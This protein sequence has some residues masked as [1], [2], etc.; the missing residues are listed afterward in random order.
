MLRNHIK[1]ALR[2]FWK[3]KLTTGINIF[4]L[5]IG[6][7]CASLA[8]IFIQHERSY[9]TFHEEYENIYWLHTSHQGGQ[10]NL[11]TTPAV[12]STSLKKNF[13][14]VTEAFRM[15]DHAISIKVGKEIFE[16]E[17]LLV[18]SNF[19]D[20]FSFPLLEGN[21]ND[22]LQKRNA[23]VLSE[24]MANKYF[25]R[26]SPI[27]KMLNI[28][29]RGQE[30]TFEVTGVA[31]DAPANSS[32]QFSVLIPIQYRYKEDL[33]KLNSDWSNFSAA[34]FIR[35]R[36]A[37]DIKSLEEKMPGFS[38]LHYEEEGAYEFVLHA[39]QDYHL[40]D[41]M[42][43]R[44]LVAKGETSY[45]NILSIIAILI[46]LV[47]CLNF[48]NLSNARGSQ[49]LTEI[50][51]RQVLGAERNQLLRQFLTESVLISSLSLGIAIGFI[52]LFQLYGSDLFS[53]NL[54][55]DWYSPKILLPLVGIT[56]ITGL[57]AGIYPSILLSNLKPIN[58]FKSD[59]KVGGN[60]WVTKGGLVFQ[61]TLSI[62]LLA[63]T[64]I[65]FQ[66]QQYLKNK[67]L[68][69]DQEQVVV[70]P[71]QIQRADSINTTR[72]LEQYKSKV[73]AHSGVQGVTAVSNSFARGNRAQF[74][75]EEDGTMGFVFEYSVADNYLDLLDIELLEGRN[76]SE[77]IQ[78]DQGK[79]VIVNEAFA[80]KYNIESIEGYRLPEKFGDFA[81]SSVVGLV[82]DYHFST[83]K[84]SV[85]PMMMHMNPDLRYG[86]LL[87]KI[88]PNEVQ[89]TLA[90][91]K[92][93]W[94]SIRPDK[95]FQFSFLDEDIQQQYEAE[96]RWNKA[97]TS[98]TILAIIIALLGLFGLVD[99]SLIQR[100]KEIGIRK[101]LGASLA[102]I[103][104]LFSLNFIK[105]ILLGFVISTPLAWYFMQERL[106]DFEYSIEIQWWVF[107]V[108]ALSVILMALLIIS[109]QSLKAIWVN[110][111]ESLRNE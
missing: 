16:E 91:L 43:T 30:N 73:L 44:G 86:H 38:A 15:E 13:S 71:T 98:T 92:T 1:I 68:G 36:Q 27:G 105:L 3:Q 85:E 89:T 32:L 42:T 80:K 74:I 54:V 101:I 97:I 110:P 53:Y 111:V 79:T 51:V 87:V 40:Q 28:A 100:T 107:P 19:F 83:L 6:I 20:F 84:S 77:S 4:G 50:G 102:H 106:A 88:N 21:T 2:S 108:A 109:I 63:S 99:L 37:D 23:V 67:N 46:L 78:E 29:W 55:I 95:T 64:F 82:K 65:L 34:S 70:I 11:S 22:V 69:F 66:Q 18:E 61:F 96:S 75:N 17:A 62:G 35:L 104:Q 94:V 14:E 52:K 56:V 48:T 26:Q 59:F 49:R 58:T 41:G 47:A 93:A 103:V 8:Y 24:S 81:N 31:K 60:N 39:Y 90:Q 72:L 57:L 33:A 12:L 9:D 5:A 25:G 10:M 45:L 7:A 76:F